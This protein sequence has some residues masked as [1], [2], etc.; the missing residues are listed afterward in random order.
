MTTSDS[1]IYD[2]DA[3]ELNWPPAIFAAEAAALIAEAPVTAD[4]TEA[5]GHLL[6]EAFTGRRPSADLRLPA[7]SSRID[8]VSGCESLLRRLI[9]DAGSIRQAPKL[10]IERGPGRVVEADHDLLASLFEELIGKLDEYG[11]LDDLM[12]VA[13]RS[14]FLVDL[15]GVP[16]L[17]PLAEGRD[18]WSPAAT[19]HPDVLLRLIRVFEALVARPRLP[20]GHPSAGPYS[21]RTGRDLYRAH[22]TRNFRRAGA[23][24]NLSEAGDQVGHLA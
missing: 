2:R 18:R 16:G 1:G 23:P 14:E 20:I 19:G 8:S 11:Y 24:P 3:Y 7:D 10:H 21:V 12:P 17:W 9:E 4:W 15:V 13:N 5:V 6:D 22:M